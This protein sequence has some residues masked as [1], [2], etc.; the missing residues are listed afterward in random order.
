MGLF[1][2]P[3]AK[4]FVDFVSNV[5]KNVS[6]TTPPAPKNTTPN[7]SYTPPVPS[8]K[9]NI[10]NTTPLPPAAKT[11]PPVAKTNP[12]S[13]IGSTDIPAFQGNTVEPAPISLAT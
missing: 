12:Y 9:N 7:K 10:G 3:I 13:G 11:N 5:A 1:D 2:N 6:Q 4:R 8:N